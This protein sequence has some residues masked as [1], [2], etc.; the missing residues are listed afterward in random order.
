MSPRTNAKLKI[1]ELL[2][3]H[4]LI[5]SNQLKDALKVQSQRGG[6]IGSLL[7]ELGYISTE[8]LLD[9][10]GKQLGI[11]T[12][13]L[14]QISIPKNV[15][16]MIPF[17]LVIKYKVLPLEADDHSITLGMVKPNDL[18]AISEIEFR[19][20]KRVNPIIVPSSQ[21]DMAIK[22]IQ[23]RSGEN[24]EG[25]SLD[26]AEKDKEVKGIVKLETML[27]YLTTSDASDMLIAAGV[28]PAI[29]IHN[30][31]RRS[32]LPSL[33]PEQCVQ[34][35]KALMSDKQWSE[36]L[37]ERQFD[38]AISVAGIGRFR[39]NA[40]R[41]RNSVSISIRHLHDIIPSFEHLGLPSW[42]EKYALK[43]QGL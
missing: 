26:K 29:K 6:Q 25:I 30:T 4:R 19:T 16:G 32:N 37:K 13:N 12:T 33:T 7:I 36:F 20:G 27:K 40:Y 34:Y 2:L 21:I 18:K 9:F 28:P 15:L 39:I 42:L 23:E 31:L 5:D 1:G 35:A 24:F 38:F 10:L 8:T 14:F 43:T 22:A 3:Q 41:Q 11:P 17:D